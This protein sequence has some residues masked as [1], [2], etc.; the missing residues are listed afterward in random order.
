VIAVVS[1]VLS[2][3]QMYFTWQTI[4]TD[5]YNNME[6]ISWYIAQIAFLLTI[7]CLESIFDEFKSLRER[8]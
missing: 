3:V 8:E 5:V 7:V 1:C 4:G 6:I 2:L